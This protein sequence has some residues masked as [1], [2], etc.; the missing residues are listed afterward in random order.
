M[1][2]IENKYITVVYKLYAV[3][4]DEKDFTEEA[5]AEHP[6]QFIS[7]LGMTLEAFETQIK[8]LKA[9]DTFD[10]TIAA[11]EAYGDYDDDHVIELP[12]EVFFIE[13]KFDDERVTEGAVL[14]LMTSGGQR[15]NGSVVEVKEDVVVMDMNHPLAGCNL[16]FTGEIVMSRPATNDEIAEAVR[17]M[18][19]GCNCDGDCGDGCGDHGCG[20]GCCH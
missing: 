9:G 7:G 11:S 18:S 10:F 16:N 5:S 19:G 1:G 8:G 15:I 20:G 14:P 13:G 2:T 6:F 12:K 3:E 17:L 4:N